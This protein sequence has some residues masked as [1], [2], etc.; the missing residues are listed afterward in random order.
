[1]SDEQIATLPAESAV[2]ETT[3]PET[4]PVAQ[5][6]VEP[7]PAV[8]A[9]VESVSNE[10]QV[11]EAP[12]RKPS[13]YY[14]ERQ[15]I[16]T[17]EDT[18]TTLSQRQEELL[19]LIKKEKEPGA[20]ADGKFDP[21]VFFQDPEKV[22]TSREQRLLNEINSLREE[23]RGQKEQ[24]VAEQKNQKSLEALEKLFPKSSP[25][26][27][28]TLQE[29]VQRDPERADRIRT[30]L[31]ES[32]LDEFSKVN[33]DLAVEIAL[34]KLAEK[35]A[36]P[37]PT[38]LKKTMM[39]GVGTGNP[40]G[41]GKAGPNEDSLRA[42]LRKLSDLAAADPNLRRDPKHVER[43]GQVMEQLERLMKEKRG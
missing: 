41:G 29:R 25:E 43:K 22:L 20:P 37:N 13:D 42:E 33:P 18:I 19:S 26:S 24:Q 6:P 7:Q 14:R 36:T 23:F 16:R 32:G 30:F 40:S 39:G 28:E 21:N 17:M 15:R 11:P 12:R 3:S 34:Q 27:K 8:S 9:P 1:M 4:L 5:A 38:V 31:K 2:V 10:P 35:P